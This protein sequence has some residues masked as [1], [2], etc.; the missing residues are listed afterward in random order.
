[1]RVPM[2][3][4]SVPPA[5]AAADGEADPLGEIPVRVPE[6]LQREGAVGALA[7]LESLQGRADVGFA[8]VEPEPRQGVQRRDDVGEPERKRHAL[9]VADVT[10]IAV[11]VLRV[12]PGGE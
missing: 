5:E 11:C 4:G 6:E 8:V 1:A 7:A 3:S 10:T 12:Q 9:P 2:P